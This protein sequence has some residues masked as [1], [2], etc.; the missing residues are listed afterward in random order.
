M[1]EPENDPHLKALL[2]NMFAVEM[3]FMQSDAQDPAILA[4]AFHAD[5]VVHEPASLPYSGDWIGLDGVA[6]L[7]RRMG[8]LFGGMAIDALV[9]A[10]S[11]ERLHLACTLTMTVRATGETI[12]QPFAELLRFKDGLLI[13]GTPF[14]HDTSELVAA[15]TP[16]R[17]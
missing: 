9:C 2:D 15:L 10:G 3:A 17:D 13:E 5:V 8:E 12:V 14:Y 7:M 16:R 6:R 11:P 1:A 4:R